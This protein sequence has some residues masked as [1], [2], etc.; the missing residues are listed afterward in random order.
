MRQLHLI[1]VNLITFIRVPLIFAFFVMAVVHAWPMQEQVNVAGDVIRPVLAYPGVAWQGLLALL[2]LFLSAITDLFDGLLARKWKVVTPFGAMCDPL[3]D[4]VFYLVVFPALL[5][6]LPIGR[7]AE[8]WHALIMLIL[9]VLY[10][11]RDQWVTFLRSVGARYG[12]DC[13]ATFL[14]KLRTAMTFPL[15]GIIY[16]YIMLDQTVWGFSFP[17]WLIYSG[18]GIAIFLNFWSIYIYTRRF[19]PYIKQSINTV[20]AT[21]S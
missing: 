12:A 1:I 17:Q 18:E 19:M 11:L 3:M 14:G 2:F 20:D 9:T 8:N 13:A 7:P 5:W 21:R 6:L 10:M 16:Y 15:C 4:K